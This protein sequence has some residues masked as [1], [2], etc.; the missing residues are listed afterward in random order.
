MLDSIT[1]PDR[2]VLTVVTGLRVRVEYALRPY[3][4]WWCGR[5]VDRKRKGE[6]S[7]IF[8]EK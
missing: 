1:H 4:W 7:R 6:R 3:V 8:E 2:A 5:R